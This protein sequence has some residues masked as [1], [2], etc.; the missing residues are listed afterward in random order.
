MENMGLRKKELK[1]MEKRNKWKNQNLDGK[2]ND[3]RR[4]KKHKR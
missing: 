4:D 2:N 3:E 1:Y